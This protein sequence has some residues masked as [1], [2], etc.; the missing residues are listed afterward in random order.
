VYQKFP[1]W[2]DNEIHAYNNKNSLRSN[3][4]GY[5]GKTHYTDTQN[6]DTTSPRSRELYHLQFSLQAASPETFVYTLVHDKALKVLLSKFLFI[7]VDCILTSLWLSL[8]F[9]RELGVLTICKL[10]LC[11]SYTFPSFTSRENKDYIIIS[12]LVYRRSKDSLAAR[13]ITD[14]LLGLDCSNQHRIK[15]LCGEMKFVFL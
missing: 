7:S 6:S 1:D 11:S 4:K 8:R 10:S 9:W 13:K 14:I 5:G 12:W 2:V 3:I 15:S